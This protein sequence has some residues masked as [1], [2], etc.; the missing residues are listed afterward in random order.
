MSFNGTE[1]NPI[2]LQQGSVLT[3]AYRKANPENTKAVFIG[4]ENIEHLLA[5]SQAMG[6]RVYFGKDTDGSNTIVMVAA[7]SN[8]DDILDLI[9]DNGKKNP[10]YTGDANDLNS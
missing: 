5:S 4:R 6:I 8:E 10:P 2:T 7:D 3:N 1:G 9:I